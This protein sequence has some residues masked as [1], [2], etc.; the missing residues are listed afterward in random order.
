[1]RA[2]SSTIR[3]T[4]WY[5]WQE[6]WRYKWHSLGMLITT[7]VVIFIRSALAPLVF[8]TLIDKISSGEIPPENLWKELWPTALTFIGVYF[9]SAVVIEK[10]R[11]FFCWKMEI[12]AM[13]NMAVRCFDHLAAHSMQFHNDRFGGSLVSQTSKFFR[14]LE[15]F[16][17]SIV[18]ELLPL[19][20][21]ITFTVVILW[22]DIPI[23]AIILLAF[24]IIYTLMA[25]FSY[26]KTESLNEAEAF[27]ENAQSGQL[28]DSVA[29]IMTVKSYGRENHEH[30][31]YTFA[32]GATFKASRALMRAII[33]RDV[34]FSFVYVGIMSALVVFLIGGRGWFGI[35]VG[36]MILIATYSQQILGNLWD[37]N[38]IMR[39][40]NRVFG[41]AS[42]MTMI[43][44]EPNAVIDIKDAKELKVDKGQISFSNISFIHPDAKES[45]FSE[46]SL[47]IEAGQRI[48]LV[49]VSGSGKT[50]LTKLLLR[51]ADVEKGEI[52]IDGQNIREV[53][54]NSLREQIAY[55][56]QE[57]ALFHR[58]IA[59]NISYGKPNATQSE[60]EYA[61]K[62]ANAAEFIETLPNGYE[63]LV[64]ERG[65]KLSGGQRQRVAIARAILKDAPILVLDEATSA[66]D[67]ESENLIQDALKRLMKGR[68]SLVI[69]HRFS[70][71]ASLDRIVVLHDGK[72][73]EQGSHKD[74]LDSG[75]EYARLW[76]RQTGA[77]LE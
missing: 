51:F 69:A 34:A 2:K 33:S 64:G 73:A 30:S 60:I 70:T 15:R 74:L 26:E 29:N 44:D 19:V 72:I 55:V 42:E 10:L 25:F 28:S 67:S 18:W 7:P 41:D 45:I 9:L 47:D 59:E 63:T 4:L 52:L 38:N 53:T 5:Y 6:I 32:A 61:A 57:T 17:D 56:P 68:T 71:V 36:T 3:R 48:G 35:S 62:L 20:S 40:F 14:S 1:M 27:A 8:A 22:R 13:Y 75:G 76:N 46:F 66:L 23:F 54:Q 24:S 43:L 16:I 37:I 49:G 39:N 21:V 11:L 58:S 77:Y 12:K 31:R 50:T 65:V